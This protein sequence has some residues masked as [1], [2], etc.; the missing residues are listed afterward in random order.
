MGLYTGMQPKC[1]LYKCT[2]GS[3]LISHC[4]W[5][6]YKDYSFLKMDSSPT[7]VTWIAPVF[8]ICQFYQYLKNQKGY[9]KPE[10]FI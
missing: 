8:K 3:D 2:I 4:H 10:L 5:W 1:M 7:S 6:I 9:I